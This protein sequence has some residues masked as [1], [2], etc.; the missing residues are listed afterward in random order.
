MA[1]ALTLA[2]PGA[3]RALMARLWLGER[4]SEARHG[5][6]VLRPH[7]RSALDR[8]RRMLREHGGALLADDVGLGKTF[9]AAAIAREYERVLVVA[10]A[11]LRRMW[12]EALRSVGA[13][14]LVVSYATLSRGGAPRGHFDLVLLDEAH[15]SRTPGTRRYARIAELADGAHLLLLSATPIHTTSGDLAALL[16]LFL[17]ERALALDDDALAR[18]V[19]RRE[20]GDV[21]TERL[22]ETGSPVRLAVGDDEELLRAIVALPPALPLRGAGSDRDGSGGGSSA[23]VTWGLARGWASSNAALVAAARRRLVR[24]GALDAALEGGRLPSRRELAAWVCGDRAVQ[25]ALPGLFNE[26]LEGDG[27]DIFFGS[28]SGVVDELRSVVA[29]HEASVRA[30]LARAMSSAWTDTRRAQLLREIR[31]RH[32]G[33][34]IAAFTQFA[35][36]ARALFRELRRDPGVAV[37]T[38]HGASVAGGALSRK[39][40][41][42]RFAP[43]A[44]GVRAPRTIERI[45]LLIA[46]DLLSEGVNL[47]DA[48][49]V[50]HLDLPWTPA[51]MEQRVGRSRRMGALHA[52]TTVYAFEPPA[53]SEVLLGVEQRLRAKLGAV[54]RLLGASDG[55]L[56]ARATHV[57]DGDQRDEAAVQHGDTSE[58]SAARRR[59][60]IAR[61]LERWRDHDFGPNSP[62][63]VGSVVAGIA[64]SAKAGLLALVREG[65]EHVLVAGRDDGEVGDDPSLVLEIVRLA[66]G[67][68]SATSD[69]VHHSAP[70][71]SDLAV[72][73]ER[74]ARWAARRAGVL[75][76]GSPLGPHAPARRR[77]LRRVAAI[78]ARAPRHRRTEVTRLAALARQVATA[79]FGVGAE[80]ALEE[81]VTA[82]TMSGEE[83]LRAL[84]DFGAARGRGGGLSDAPQVEVLAILV[85]TAGS[86][87]GS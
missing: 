13:R 42:E 9:V 86:A 56:L 36:T 83:W 37:L 82:E 16:A 30:L 77:A 65:G 6:I 53:S 5:T 50:V 61:E 52:R 87:L 75:A 67:A 15:H 45:D 80:R 68:P 24:A 29:V 76:A 7:Q 64:R 31:A 60:L 2:H 23:L 85:L 4:R 41:I 46:T 43:R 71:S 32:P 18:H 19:V 62:V 21:P 58:E 10:P 69:A 17:G 78:A 8:V 54:G 84:G 72:A 81:L 57:R 59:E 70:A 74:V 48:S 3:V 79:P 12:Q 34:K 66:I 44:S 20:R 22:P 38:A 73:L 55:V 26:P 63:P 35:D 1:R 25:L 27:V 39:E 49:V 40:A 33:E 47:H 11:T 28:S 14:G 51:R